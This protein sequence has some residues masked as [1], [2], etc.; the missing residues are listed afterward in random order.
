MKM[1]VPT[2]F[3]A[4]S[5]VRAAGAKHHTIQR[6]ALFPPFFNR[7]TQAFEKPDAR[8]QVINGE[9]WR[10]GLRLQCAFSNS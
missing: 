1:R 2:P 5:D 8:R 3:L 7:K 4:E 10:D 9:V 6:A